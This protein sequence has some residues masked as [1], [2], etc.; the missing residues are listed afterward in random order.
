[1]SISLILLIV[2]RFTILIHSLVVSMMYLLSSIWRWL[3]L[4]LYF[5]L[6]KIY[7]LFLRSE[8]K[9]W[10]VG[11]TV[12]ASSNFFCLFTWL[13]ASLWFLIIRVYGTFYRLQRLHVVVI[14]HSLMTLVQNHKWERCS[15]LSYFFLRE[16]VCCALLVY[17]SS[18]E[19]FS[20][21]LL[22]Y[23][24]WIHCVL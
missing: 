24:F 22:W 12:C 13:I 1:M 14:G 20:V 10:L 2:F 4:S 23:N 17:D 15:T 8:G 11:S 5:D 3:Y 16:L 6:T 21:W 9:L 18:L 19:D 7:I